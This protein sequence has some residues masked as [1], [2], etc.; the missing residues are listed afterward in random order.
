MQNFLV[1]L[2]YVLLTLQD[3]LL[4]R[5]RKIQTNVAILDFSKAFDTVPHDRLLVKLWFFGI[6]GPLLDWTAAFLKTREQTVVVDRRRSSACKSFQECPR[7]PF[8]VHYYFSCIWTIFR[9]LSP[10]RLDYSPITASCIALSVPSLISLSPIGTYLPWNGGAMHG[11]WGST[12]SVS[13]DIIYFNVNAI[14]YPYRNISG[15]LVNTNWWTKAKL[16]MFAKLYDPSLQE[17]H[18]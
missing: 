8:E 13:N 10:H 1:K 9:S 15:D 17:L 6:Q 4:A 14:I 5:Y 7:A 12:S 2:N 11:A 16:S 18:S 3:L